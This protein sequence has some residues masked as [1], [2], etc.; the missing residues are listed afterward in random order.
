MK[1]R[2]EILLDGKTEKDMLLTFEFTDWIDFKDFLRSWFKY[3]TAKDIKAKVNV[4]EGV[5]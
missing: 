3:C 5:E 4:H 1:I 2:L